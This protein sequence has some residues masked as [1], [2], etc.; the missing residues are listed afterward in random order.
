MWCIEVYVSTGVYQLLQA[1]RRPFLRMFT[2]IFTNLLG[3]RRYAAAVVW[4]YLSKRHPL[5][6]ADRSLI[7]AK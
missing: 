1:S 6:Q 7:Y 5:T 3:L 4:L 2:H